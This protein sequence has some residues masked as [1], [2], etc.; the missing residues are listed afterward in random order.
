MAKHR[1]T[2]FITYDEPSLT[3]RSIKHALHDKSIEVN[4]S[5]TATIPDLMLNLVLRSKGCAVLPYLLVR[6]YLASGE[7]V[8]PRYN[9]AA[10]MVPRNFS[11]LA[12]S[13]R[14]LPAYITSFLDDIAAIMTVQYNECLDKY[15]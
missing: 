15:K 14:V 5:I 2:N 10:M 9:E 13:N 7:L 8:L 4:T 6:S 12:L 1:I 3:T 11:V